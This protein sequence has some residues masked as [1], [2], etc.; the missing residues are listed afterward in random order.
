VVDCFARGPCAFNVGACSEEMSTY[1]LCASSSGSMVCKDVCE[2][3]FQCGKVP[4]EC[5]VW[6][7]KD[8]RLLGDLGCSTEH[9]AYLICGMSHAD[10]CDVSDVGCGAEDMAILECGRN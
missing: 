8:A 7:G 5:L 9:D 4:P 3:E 1:A 2:R 6:C 10:P